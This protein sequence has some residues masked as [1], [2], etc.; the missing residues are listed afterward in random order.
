MLKYRINMD[1]LHALSGSL[2][3]KKTYKYIS[4]TFDA[5][6][7]SLAYIHVNYTIVL[8]VYYSN[9]HKNIKFFR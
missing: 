7:D 8:Y 3:S 5:N 2:K 4:K 6:L 1:I 9:I